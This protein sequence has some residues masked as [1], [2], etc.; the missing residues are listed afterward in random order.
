MGRDGGRTQAEGSAERT[1]AGRKATA[2]EKRKVSGIGL[3]PNCTEDYGRRWLG[4]GRTG[5]CKT[6]RG[7][8]TSL[9]EQG[10]LGGC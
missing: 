7:P 1:P 4:A 2:R 3:E 9:S 5:L 8:D 6:L 10:A